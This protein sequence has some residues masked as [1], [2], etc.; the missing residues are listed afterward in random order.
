MTDALSPD[1]AEARDVRRAPGARN[2]ATPES[3]NGGLDPDHPGGGGA[4]LDGRAPG[5]LLAESGPSDDL[6]PD[7][8]AA[9]VA[10]AATGDRDA[11]GEYF[12]RMLPSLTLTAR[13]IAGITHDADDLLGDAVLVVLAKWLD[14][15]GP[16]DNVPA[17]IAQIMRNRIRD[18][19]RSPRSRVA[20]LENVDEP[21]STADPR[22]REL[23]IESELAIVRRAL[24]ELPTDQQRV[25]VATVLEGRKPRDLEEHMARPASAIYSLTRRAKGNLRRTTLRLL[26]EEGARP[27]CVEAAQLLPE[28]VGDTLEQTRSS[29]AT[30]HHRGCPYCRRS[31]KRFAGLAT[32]GMLPVAAGIALAGPADQ[33]T[34]ATTDAAGGAEA[35]TAADAGNGA[36]AGAGADAASHAGPDAAAGAGGPGGGAPTDASPGRSWHEWARTAAM[37][38]AAGTALVLVTIVTVTFATKTWFFAETPPGTLDVT[39]VALDPRTV[40]IDMQ[41][42]VEEQSWTVGTL[43]IDLSAEVESVEPPDGWT[44][45]VESGDAAC[46][47]AL[48]SPAGGAFTITHAAAEQVS[49]TLSFDGRSGGGAALNGRAAGVVVD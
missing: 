17:Y 37:V 38:T 34:A 20:A 1:A 41:M 9:L 47:T 11:A 23:E 31:W 4:A 25:L 14:G 49:Y 15:T 33:A 45:L 30:D 39:A 48:V 18:D 13:R 42:A 26:L 24:A 36:N 6:D 3:P 2:A 5:D 16:T 10:R 46:T 12:A 7:V 44:C 27:A 21:A 43:R 28:T 8:L 35:G 32:L 29:R 22:L 40:E 19:F